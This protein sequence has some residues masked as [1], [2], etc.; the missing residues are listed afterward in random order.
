MLSNILV[1]LLMEFY[2]AIKMGGMGFVFFD[3][4]GALRAGYLYVV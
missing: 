4:E 1:G 3:N 2:G